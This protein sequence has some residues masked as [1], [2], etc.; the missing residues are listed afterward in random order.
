MENTPQCPHCKCY[1]MSFD[2]VMALQPEIKKQLTKER[3]ND[4]TNI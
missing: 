2:E 3:K 1:G 4:E